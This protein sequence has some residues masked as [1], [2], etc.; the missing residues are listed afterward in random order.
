MTPYVSDAQTEE[1][2][3]WWRWFEHHGDGF[4]ARTLLALFAILD[5]VIIFFPPE[6]IISAL[7]LAK[8]KKW[9]FYTLYT[10]FFTTVGAIITYILGAY[11]FD[12]FGS[13]LLPLVGGAAAFAEAQHV[14]DSN[15]VLGILFVGIT[16]IPWVPF[17]LASGVFKVNFGLFLFGVVLARIIRF[18]II[19][20]L[21]AH[22]GQR[23]LA[24]VLKTLRVMGAAG[25]ILVVAALIISSSLFVHFIL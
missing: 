23:G 24:L 2:P 11:F 15:I 18:G 10:T 13:S 17:L 25:I 14:F 3:R 19:A 5:S 8:P 22:L 6:I 16:P 9:I 20:A 4:V 12:T 21:V 7:V 1:L